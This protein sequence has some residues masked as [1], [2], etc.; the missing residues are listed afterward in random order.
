[1]SIVSHT[2]KGHTLAPPNQPPFQVSP[3]LSTLPNR[4]LDWTNHPP[5][6]LRFAVDTTH[7]LPHHRYP[8]PPH[9]PIDGDG[10]LG[11][12]C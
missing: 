12:T 6:L 10:C 8:D 7:G 1:M 3:F 9:H 11:P 4:D 2:H 5:R